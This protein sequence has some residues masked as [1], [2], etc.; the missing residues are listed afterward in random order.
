MPKVRFEGVSKLYGPYLAVQDLNFEVNDGEFL[1]MVG[2]SGCGKSTTLRMLAGL[3]TP[4]Y[5]RIWL[6]DKDI[7]LQ[8]PGKREV[9]MVFQSYA[10]Y[11]HMSVAKNLS[12][13]MEV[14]GNPGSTASRACRRLRTCSA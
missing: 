12:F 2:P 4:S 8:P 10:L 7:T 1:V 9:A 14:R 6:D 3:E 5:G 13:G 11:P